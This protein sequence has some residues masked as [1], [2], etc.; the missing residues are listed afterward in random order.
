M[1]SFGGRFSGTTPNGYYLFVLIDLYSRYMIVEPMKQTTSNEVIRVLKEIFT[2][3]GLPQ[4]ITLDNAMNFS[5]QLMKDFCVDRGIKLTHTT[6]YWPSA[7]GEAERQNQS[8]LKLSAGGRL[9]SSMTAKRVEVRVGT[10]KYNVVKKVLYIYKYCV[11]FFN[12]I[13][14]VRKCD[15]REGRVRKRRKRALDTAT[16]FRGRI[17]PS[18]TSFSSKRAW[19]SW[20]ECHSYLCSV[21]GH[22]G[23]TVSTWPGRHHRHLGTAFGVTH[24]ITPV[25]SERGHFG[26]CW[27]IAKLSFCGSPSQIAKPVL[28]IAKPVPIVKPSSGGSPSSHPAHRQAL[29]LWIA[30][31]LPIVKPS[32]GGSPSRIAK[33]DRQERIWTHE[34]GMQE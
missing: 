8:L 23:I 20:R 28:W 1:D 9:L 32:S 16:V 29:V 7:N 12:R 3:L 2:R 33:P 22:S 24:R 6:P 10:Y 5:S 27:R 13:A 26:L 15:Y 11:R 21:S 14:G 18:W 34:Y 17:P 4:V 19:P 30:K 25:A 31:P